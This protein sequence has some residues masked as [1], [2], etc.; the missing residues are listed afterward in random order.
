MA[1][2]DRVQKYKRILQLHSWGMNVPDMLVCY[3]DKDTPNTLKEIELWLSKREVA[4]IRT[5]SID[6]DTTDSGRM[7]EERR[8]ANP[9]LL[10]QPVGFL[11]AEAYRL[12]DEGFV[13][14]VEDFSNSFTNYNGTLSLWP[15]TTRFWV[16]YCTGVKK[17]VRM[18]DKFLEGDFDDLYSTLYPDRIPYEI[19]QVVHIGACLC[20][21]RP[22]IL[23]WSYSIEPQG[24]RLENVI[25]WEYRSPYK[26]WGV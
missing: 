19:R 13:I 24:R 14:M 10:Q 16:D 20:P 25:F 15:D 23:E 12:V 1:A 18:V 6:I 21:I 7:L 22:V 26:G 4:N 5:Y 8:K 11:I 2:S 3:D 9:H 17:T